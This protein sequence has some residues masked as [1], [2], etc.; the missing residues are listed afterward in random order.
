MN[1]QL[2]SAGVATA[3][4]VAQFEAPDTMTLIGI[5]WSAKVA[6]DAAGEGMR[7][8]LA[9]GQT[10]PGEQSGNRGVVSAIEVANSFVT[11]G[12][13]ATVNLFVPC[14]EKLVAGERLYLH[15]E[16]TGSVTIA[17]VRC[18]LMFDKDV[19]RVSARRGL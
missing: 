2:F 9:F 12:E 14:N 11:A 18:I 17:E 1:E 15:A 13:Y 7:Y 16:E 3:A 19:A 6:S 4:Q 8:T 10:D 5:Q